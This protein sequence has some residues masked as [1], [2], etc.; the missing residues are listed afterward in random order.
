MPRWALAVALAA[1][2]SLLAAAAIPDA[3]SALL[4]FLHLGGARIELV[5]ELPTVATTDLEGALG[6][7]VT[8]EE[9]R[10]R[11]G[12]AL[13]ELDHQPD[14]V[15]LGPRGTVWFLYGTPTH[16]RLLVAQTPRSTVDPI[17]TRKIAGADTHVEQVEVD[18]SPGALLMGAPHVVLLVDER[19]RIVEESAR[20]ARDVLL[21]DDNGI[22]YRLEGD[23]EKEEAI[24]LAGSLR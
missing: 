2:V 8:L 7:R 24:E 20:L 11:G 13:R 12:F 23:F 18:G 4:R 5:D 21:W 22:V 17:F 10:E 9:A 16:V 14:R 3:R 15:Y 19:G 1:L 6:E